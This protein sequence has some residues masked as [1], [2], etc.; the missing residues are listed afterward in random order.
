MNLKE[1]RE[2]YMRW[3]ESEGRNVIYMMIVK[4]FKSIIKIKRVYKKEIDWN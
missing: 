4:I 3:F 2:E 1:S